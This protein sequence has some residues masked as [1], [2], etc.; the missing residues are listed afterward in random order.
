MVQ[1]LSII[2]FYFFNFVGFFKSS[3]FLCHSEHVGTRQHSTVLTI[4]IYT[5][6]IDSG[7]YVIYNNPSPLYIL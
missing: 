4:N 6:N 5:S 3:R 7:M 2:V 1:F